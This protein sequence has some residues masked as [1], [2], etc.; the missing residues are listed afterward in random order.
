MRLLKHTASDWLTTPKI[1]QSTIIINMCFIQPQAVSMN[2]D[3]QFCKVLQK[4]G[5]NI[6]LTTNPIVHYISVI[7]IICYLL[8]LIY[9]IHQL[10]LLCKVLGWNMLIFYIWTFILSFCVL[11]FLIIC[12]GIIKLYMKVFLLYIYVAYRY[13]HHPTQLLLIFGFLQPQNSH[14]SRV[15]K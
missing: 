6:L 12:L 2:F 7:I 4:V 8:C 10:L 13:I 14:L 5:N 9:I 1:L 11:H 3:Y 15:D